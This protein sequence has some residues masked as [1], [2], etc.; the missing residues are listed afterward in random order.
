MTLIEYK[1]I[2][3]ISNKSYSSSRFSI[4]NENQGLYLENEEIFLRD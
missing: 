1:I 4:K 3:K 2:V